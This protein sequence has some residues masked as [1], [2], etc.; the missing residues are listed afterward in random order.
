MRLFK[1]N[2]CMW[3]SVLKK[4]HDW[5]STA[6]DADKEVTVEKKLEFIILKW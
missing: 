5:P 1:E 4:K 6:E 3:N 2:F